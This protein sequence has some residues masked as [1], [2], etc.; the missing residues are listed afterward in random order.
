MHMKP[1]RGIRTYCIVQ[2]LSSLK[3]VYAP[4]IVSH[5]AYLSGKEVSLI[6]GFHIEGEML[7]VG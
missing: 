6:S 3:P 2:K 7:E 1:A 5:K 4:G